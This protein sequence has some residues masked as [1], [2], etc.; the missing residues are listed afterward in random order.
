MV[1]KHMA[2]KGLRQL[3]REDFT[4]LAAKQEGHASPTNRVK[5]EGEDYTAR[6]RSRIKVDS[7]AGKAMYSKPHSLEPGTFHFQYKRMEK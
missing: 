5:L 3:K 1:A 6:A 4:R 7:F 2:Q